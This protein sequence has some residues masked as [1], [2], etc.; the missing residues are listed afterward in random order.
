L[1]LQ[2]LHDLFPEKDEVLIPAYT[3]Y[4]VPSAIVRAG[5]KVRLCEMASGALDF[6]SDCLLKH[7]DNPRLLCI[8]PTHLFGLP[9]DVDKA[10]SLTKHLGILVVEDAAQ[11]MGGE[12]N[13]KKLG[14]MGDIGIFSM[15]RGKAFSTVEGGVIL[16]N[17]KVIS[18]AIEKR[19][20]N[21]GGYGFFNCL[22]L[23]M[24]AVALAVLIHPWIYWLPKLLP[25]LRLGETNFNKSFPIRRLSSFQAGLTKDWITR[26]DE[27]REGRRRISREFNNCG[28]S[29]P[30]FSDKV[31]PDLIRFPIL[32]KDEVTKQQILSKSEE[33]GLGIS[34]GYPGTIDGI[35][36]LKYTTDGNVFPN[37]KDFAER[38]VTLPVHPLTN[39][40]DIRNII[41]LLKLALKT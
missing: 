13:G 32:L 18:E 3:C 41:N 10:K 6:D 38:L 16:T 36:V 30:G 1:I 5:F 22:K 7:L 20:I 17:N 27:H 11:A 33:L 14:T 28:I 40:N 9:A 24:Y 29:P 31:I 4:S 26:I 19:F 39:E 15:G 34:D 37:A 8:I 12:W 23:I 25:F 21:I 35:K 2:A